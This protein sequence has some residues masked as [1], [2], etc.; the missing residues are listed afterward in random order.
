[1]KP[2]KPPLQS[3]RLLDQLRERIR[4]M[5]YSLRTEQAY[6]Y[7]V[8]FFIRWHGMKHPRDMGE[9]A[10]EAFS[11]MLA[12]DRKVSAPP[13]NQALGAMLFLYREVL[14][15]DFPWL[16]NINRPNRPKRR[17]ALLSKDEVSRLLAAM[18][19]EVG[20]L[21]QLLYGTGMRL[22]EALRLRIKD[23]AFDRRVIICLKSGCN[24]R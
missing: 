4:Y 14:D 15:I 1:M 7:W 2:G 5:H 21:A 10:I 8:R 11:T 23:E 20:L 9:P 17:P 19:G 6:L 22:M 13:H 3:A 18:D 16:Q 12:T 24:A